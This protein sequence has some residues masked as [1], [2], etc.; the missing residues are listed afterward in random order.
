VVIDDL[1]LEGIRAFPLEAHPPLIVDANTVLTSPI[2]SQL[3][4]A[5][6]GRDSEVIQA[7]RC[8]KKQKLSQH[9]ALEICRK[10]PRNL[11][12]EEP[13]RIPVGEAADHPA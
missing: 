9:R 6:T 7:F 5:I 11:P 13:R 3:L 4:Q 1:D 12:R 10:A 2:A 8:I